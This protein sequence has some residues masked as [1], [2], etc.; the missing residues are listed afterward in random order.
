MITIIAALTHEGVIGKEGGLP[1]HLPEDM[2]H[3][4]KVTAGNTV[5]MGRKTYESIPAKFRPLPKRHN[6]VISRS[7]QEIEGADVCSSIQD[8]L[9][10]AQEYGKEVFVIGGAQIYALALP[11]AT[12]L[13]LS[14]VRESH[15]GDIYFPKF[16][17]ENWEVV[18]TTEFDKFTLKEY[19]RKE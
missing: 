3:F 12:K 15:P 17:K 11:F 4:R 8:A 9:A 5:V 18:E 19:R 10:K 6:I 16:N 14:H 7:V 1:W 2:A 13:L